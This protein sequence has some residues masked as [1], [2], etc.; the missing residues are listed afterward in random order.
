MY[1]LTQYVDEHPGG[2]SILNN[3]G[4]DSTEGFHG[5]QHPAT[6][7]YSPTHVLPHCPCIALCN[8]NVECLPTRPSR[9]PYVR[10][11]IIPI[12]HWSLTIKTPCRHQLASTMQ[13]FVM[14]EDFCIGRL[15]D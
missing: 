12:P 2:D 9:P 14:N 13:V 1:D 11:P 7:R 6:V 4:G 5:P 8:G 15:H 10:P 3:V